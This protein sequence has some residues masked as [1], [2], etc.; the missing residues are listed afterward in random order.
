MICE[1]GAD[2]VND[3]IVGFSCR[4]N[5]EIDDYLRNRAI[6][7]TRK[8]MTMTHLVFE[9]ETGL[10]V[11]YFALTH[12]PL[13]LDGPFRVPL[14][15]GRSPWGGMKRRTAKLDFRAMLEFERRLW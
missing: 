3:V 15:S 14:V 11:G 2:V 9:T 12:K 6:D 1:Q 4:Y 10:C 5:D 13:T 7:F 8:S